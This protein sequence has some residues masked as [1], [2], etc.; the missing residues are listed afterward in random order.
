MAVEII[1]SDLTDLH[2]HLGSASTPHFLWELAHEQGI[3]L[4]HKDYWKFIES[5]R[6]RRKT[7]YEK[8]LSFFDLTELIQSSTYAV[9]RAVHYAISHAYRTA[10]IR[11]IEIRFNP[12]FRN[13]GGLADLDKIILGAVIGMKK[14]TL[15]YPV[16]AG[17]ILMMDRRFNKKQN[18]IIA[19]KAIKFRTDGVVGL[20]IAG[21]LNPNFKMDDIAEAV[22]CA[23]GG[24]LKITIHTG[25]VT[26]S[27]EVWEV[28]EK[29]RPDRIGHGIKSAGDKNLLR[30]LAKRKVV[31]EVCPT[32]NIYT[33]AVKN[34]NEMADII[35]KLW[36]NR[37]LFTIN[38]DGP[39]LLDV[40]VKSEFEKL[41]EKRIL[42]INQVKLLIKQAKQSTFV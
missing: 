10:D 26:S 17:I 42:T 1:L 18:L 41:I 21:P 11:T 33:G 9:E 28:L 4:E 24:G 31:L 16:R 30:E 29:L 19:Q 7:T 2:L 12:M 36:H 22:E 15:D 27:A 5:V 14:A 32:S 20:D 40:S 38:S 25:E 34:W 3:K 13:R 8:Y 23:R 39:E 6:L 35:D 37:V